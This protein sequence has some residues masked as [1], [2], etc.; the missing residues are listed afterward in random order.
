MI[1]LVWGSP[2][3]ELCILPSPPWWRRWPAGSGFSSS[4]FLSSQEEVSLGS[5]RLSN[6]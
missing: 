2:D 5:P 6:V 4:F 1:P 3:P